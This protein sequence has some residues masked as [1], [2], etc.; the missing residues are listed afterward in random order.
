MLGQVRLN[1][2]ALIAHWLCM[3]GGSSERPSQL[4][5]TVDKK[6]QKS[7]K[8]LWLPHDPSNALPQTGPEDS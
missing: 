5:P 8:E 6:P 3:R 4:G 1:L 2:G 7:S